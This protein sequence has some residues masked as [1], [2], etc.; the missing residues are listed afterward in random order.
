MRQ[1]NNHDVLALPFFN[2]SNFQEVI[3][4]SNYVLIDI[5]FWALVQYELRRRIL[6]KNSVFVAAQINVES[7]VFF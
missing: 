3:A 4:L 7:Q 1:V 6:E 5:L 2:Y